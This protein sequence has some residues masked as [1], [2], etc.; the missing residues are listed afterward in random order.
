LIRFS[1]EEVSGGFFTFQ[2][3]AMKLGHWQL[4]AFDTFHVTIPVT[5]LT[6]MDLLRYLASVF[7]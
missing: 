6:F 4:K 5:E 3:N 7:S 2:F 1:I